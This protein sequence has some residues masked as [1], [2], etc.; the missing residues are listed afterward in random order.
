MGAT[1]GGLNRTA[2]AVGGGSNQSR[3]P[4]RERTVW[5]SSVGAGKTPECASRFSEKYETLRP[6]PP[7]LRSE[8]LR[9]SAACMD[10]DAGGKEKGS[11][12]FD[13]R[14]AIFISPRYTG[15]VER[16][17]QEFKIKRLLPD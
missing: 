17:T 15:S 14:M 2:P 1:A 3:R 9:G 11:P 4:R 6:S 8:K 13:F 10:V 12:A 16:R 5:S 7:D